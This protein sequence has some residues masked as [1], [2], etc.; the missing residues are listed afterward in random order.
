MK[1]IFSICALLSALGFCS[2]QRLITIENGRN[3]KPYG[4]AV[5][6]EYSH[7]STA[8]YPISYYKITKLEDGTVQLAYSSNNENDIHLIKI[9]EEALSKIK[10]VVQE[11]KLH[12]LAN[13]YKPILKIL[14]GYM[15]HI[16]IH[17]EQGYI[18]S[19]GSNAYPK[20]KHRNGIKA[21]NTYLDSLIRQ[22]TP[23]D[24]LGIAYHYN[25]NED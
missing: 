8:A 13:S 2:R 1:I 15:W 10:Q 12:K 14:D 22:Q 4:N 11:Y 23:A 24:S 6:Y 3:E 9:S 5:S 21:I 19:H 7:K 16:Y 17:F 25:N 18:S 20:T